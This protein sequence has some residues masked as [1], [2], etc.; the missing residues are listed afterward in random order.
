VRD[1][2]ASVQIEGSSLTLKEAFELAGELP[3]RELRPAEHEFVNYLNAFEALDAFRGDRTAR[4]TKGDL[5]NLHRMI[6]GG[7]RGGARYAGQPRREAVQVGD[8]GADGTVIHHSPPPWGEVEPEVEALLDW[9]E[10]S[11]QRGDGPGDPWV[12]PVI[13]AGITQH[14]LVWIHPF[15]DGNGRTARM[16]TTL[17]LYQRGYDFKFL[18][19]LSGYYNRDRDKY[20]AALRTADR[21]GDY[22]E[23]LT[24]F[25]GGFAWQMVRIKERAREG[26]V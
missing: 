12:H 10:A 6:V 4:V 17:L 24:Y 22:T 21:T 3:E 5:L 20:Y 1:A 2:L 13:L 16:L 25:L 19:E 18:F 23:W 11:K 15:V 9:V 8:V 26:A 14:R 7:V